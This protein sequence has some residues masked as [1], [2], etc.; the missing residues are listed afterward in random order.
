MAKETQVVYLHRTGTIGLAPGVKLQPGV[1][2]ID[3]EVFAQLAESDTRTKA[4]LEA[5]EKFGITTKPLHED[6]L[7]RIARGG[8]ADEIINS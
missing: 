5:G 4:L 6:V 3:A 8:K 2:F 7:D 1:N